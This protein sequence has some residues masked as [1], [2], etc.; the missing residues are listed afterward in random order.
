ML[1]NL[2]KWLLSITVTLAIIG[3]STTK[4]SV[5]EKAVYS[6]DSTKSYGNGNV[7]YINGIPILTVKGTNYEMGYQ[8]GYLMKERLT[9]FNTVFQNIKNNG[10]NG[11]GFFTRLLAGFYLDGMIDKFMQ[12]IPQ[13]YIEEIKGMAEG[14]GIPLEDMQFIAMAGN[15]TLATSCS[16]I[17]AK[18]DNGILHGRNLDWFNFV[19][20]YSLVVHYEPNGKNSFYSVGVVGY[21]GVFSG[22]SDQKI[23]LTANGV[24]GGATTGFMPCLYKFREILETKTTLAE[25]EQELKEFR[26]DVA[27]NLTVSSA[28]EKNG[29]VFDLTKIGNLKSSLDSNGYL[30]AINRFIA[31]KDAAFNFNYGYQNHYR[32]ERYEKHIADKP[33]TADQILDIMADNNFL[34]CN[35]KITGLETINQQSTMHTMVFDLANDALYFNFA[36]GYAPSGNIIKYDLVINAALQYRQA[37]DFFKSQLVEETRNRYHQNF[38]Q[39][40][41]PRTSELEYDSL[42]LDKLDVMLSFYNQINDQCSPRFIDNAIKSAETVM[43]EVPEYGMSYLT[44]GLAYQLKKDYPEAETLF[45]IALSKNLAPNEKRLTLI[46]LCELYK[47]I[48]DKKKLAEQFAKLQAI[49]YDYKDK[50]S[51]NPTQQ[52]FITNIEDYLK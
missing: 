11:Q 35:N 43:K 33:R 50:I 52:K 1:N 42:N 31:A 51:K 13:C 25:V 22:F 40:F 7:K 24:N 30:F 32:A 15:F 8:Y 2:V 26:S 37:T 29:T 18:T 48:N 10:I 4:I 14:S 5:L 21:P 39:N 6:N 44:A 36:E 34:G 38:Y 17:L 20:D 27:F 41:M 46:Y 28:K 45:L 19:A 49:Y 3:C 12:R 9:K 47:T 23:A 16:S